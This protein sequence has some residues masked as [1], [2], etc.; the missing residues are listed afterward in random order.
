[1]ILQYGNTSA[2]H[3]VHFVSWKMVGWFV[4]LVGLVGRTQN[5]SQNISRK[6]LPRTHASMLTEYQNISEYF[7]FFS[8]Y[9][10][11]R[12]SQER[13]F[14]VSSLQYIHGYADKN[15]L[16]GIHLS[17]VKTYFWKVLCWRHFVLLS[18]A[19]QPY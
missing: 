6:S 9:Q 15:N 5:Y 1:M 16:R 4:G 18:V 13:V 19:Q 17:L 3:P 2:F 8:E 7:F 14:P 10:N 11:V 12:I